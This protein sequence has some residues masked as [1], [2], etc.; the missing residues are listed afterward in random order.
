MSSVR[1]VPVTTDMDGEALS[2]DDAWHVLRRVGLVKLLRDALL[3]FRY[4]DGFSHARAFGLQLALA[5]VPL[6][7]AGSGLA[8][9]VGA[10]SVAQ[11]VARTV[12]AVSPGA[13]DQLL[14]DVVARGPAELPE[15]AGDEPEDSRSE[16]VGELAVAFGLVTAFLAMTSAIAQLERGTNR[17]Y[18]TERDRPALRKYARAALLT[19]TAGSALGVG[20]VLIIAGGPLGDAVE[21]VYRWG[22]TAETI[23]DVLRWP[24]GL[25][26]LVVAV[27][28][29]FR[30]SPRRHQPGLSWLALGAGLTV[31]LWLAA[32]GCVAL[33]VALSG[34]FSDTYGPLAGIMALLL[35]AMVT[36]IALLLG[37]AVAAQ[38]EAVRAGMGDPLL[39]DEDADGIPDELQP[40]QAAEPVAPDGGRA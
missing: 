15:E 38:L 32:S 16:N 23:F 18:G 1:A 20:L 25:A 3:R 35:W 2:A 13:G 5:T 7:I 11:V 33:Y 17:I 12:V 22:D 9:A 37:V 28:V 6:V 30:F 29:L 39:R 4:G 19:V 26:A 24:V 34:D 27:T 40:R 31:L 14:A 8:T 36:G 21:Y 10:E